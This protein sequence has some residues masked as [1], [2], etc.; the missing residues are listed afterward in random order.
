MI[1]KA[2]ERFFVNRELHKIRHISNATCKLDNELGSR[3]LQSKRL[4]I[5]PTIIGNIKSRSRPLVAIMTTSS[6][7]TVVDKNGNPM[8][9][10]TQ[11][12]GLIILPRG[13]H[14]LIDSPHQVF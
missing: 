8:K 9:V 14:Q 10:S 2:S 12:A 7:L 5:I 6:A 4:V 1:F 3:N 11:I 13:I